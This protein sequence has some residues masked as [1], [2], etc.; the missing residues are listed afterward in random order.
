VTNGIPVEEGVPPGD[1][2]IL[3]Y[4]NRNFH[5]HRGGSFKRQHLHKPR[6]PRKHPGKGR[7]PRK[8]GLGRHP[9]HRARRLHHTPHSFKIHHT[10]QRTHAG[11]VPAI[12]FKKH[13]PFHVHYSL[14]NKEARIAKGLGKHLI[15]HGHMTL[16]LYV[17]MA[18]YR[19]YGILVYNTDAPGHREHTY[20]YRTR[21]LTPGPRVGNHNAGAHGH[22]PT[23]HNLT[24]PLEEDLHFFGTN[25]PAPH[26]TAPPAPH[27]PPVFKPFR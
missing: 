6:G 27:V 15:P 5:T 4:T 21:A 22:R 7:H 1:N 25:S 14:R 19:E 26:Y 16:L 9:G 23:H 24:I 3:D 10:G 2:R 17:D 8:P 12:H 13:D 18:I 11:R 20:Q